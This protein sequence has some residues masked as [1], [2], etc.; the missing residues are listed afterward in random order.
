M[1]NVFNDALKNNDK[2]NQRLKDDD[3]LY[4]RKFFENI[5]KGIEY[6]YLSED[7]E[8]LVVASGGLSIWKKINNALYFD[9]FYSIHNKDYESRKERLLEKFK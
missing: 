4:Y 7:N 6:I 5:F 9:M 8:V 2:Y 3:V 1:S